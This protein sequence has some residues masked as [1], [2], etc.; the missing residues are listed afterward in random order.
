MSDY[1]AGRPAHLEEEDIE[2]VTKVIG[3]YFD[4]QE[5][6]SKR[7]TLTGL[8]LHLGFESRQSF[9]DYEKKPAFTYVLKRARLICEN[10]LA[11]KLTD[12]DSAT[13]GVIFGLKQFGW[14][15]TV[16]Q[17]NIEAEKIP[18]PKFGE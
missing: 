11:E 17:T 13:A 3:E 14:K 1:Y 5:T 6:K 15:D 12:R 18:I 10:G 9:Y 7:A 4:M 2:A 16:E 8:A